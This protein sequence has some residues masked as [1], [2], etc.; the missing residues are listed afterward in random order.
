MITLEQVIKLLDNKKL[1]RNKDCKEDTQ[2]EFISYDSRNIK[3]NSLFFCKGEHYK[4]EY[5][6]QAI[7]KGAVV[8]I[9]EEKYD[10]NAQYIVVTDIQKAMAI[11]AAEFYG[12][13]FR[14]LETIGITGTKGK[15]T[16]TC[17]IQNILNEYTKSRT[18]IISTINTYTGT[19]D[20]LSQMTTPEAV[21]LQRLFYEAK[22][23]N[24][25]YLTMEVSSQ[26]YK[27][28]RVYGVEFKNGIFL[29]IGEDHI[30]AREHPNFEDYLHCKIQLVK[31]SKR[32]IINK[33]TDYFN[34]IYSESKNAQQVITYGTDETADYYYSNVE[35]TKL[36]FK[37]NAISKANNYNQ[38]FEINIPGRFNIE[39]ALVA[40]TLAKQLGVDDDSIRLGLLKTV[41]KGRMNVFEKN[42]ITVIVDYAHNKL[43]YT[44][45]YESL[46][47]DY[48]N[49][50]IVSVGGCV[51]GKAYNRREEFGKIVGG[52]SDYVYLTAVDPQYEKVEDIC[53]DIALYIDDKSK[54]E[55]IPDRKTAVEKAITSAKEGDVVVLVGKGEEEYQKINGISEKY[56]SDLAIAK[57]MLKI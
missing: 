9:S 11:I 44:K 21:D 43:S 36:G 25:K 54:Y 15:T 37:F 31:N 7:S 1:I 57:R 32:V 55:I 10:I 28:D 26:G 34:V 52:N 12:Y 2:I 13:A 38:K 47:L 41:V 29:N 18:A 56:E 3:P 17:F 51:G 50:R 23:N 27:K 22:Q 46:K 45:L 33:N 8:Y 40:I 39:N 19:T 49:R 6:E 53:R 4:T 35:K 14:D 30:S 5:L 20:E 24:C 42:G 48:P 16:V